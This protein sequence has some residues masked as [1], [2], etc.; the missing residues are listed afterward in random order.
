MKYVVWATVA[1]YSLGSFAADPKYNRPDV[2]QLQ[3][4]QSPVPWQQAAPLDSLPK[5][6]W[7]KIFGDIELDQY[8]DRAIANNQT[9]RAA[10][11]RLAEARAFARVT[12]AGLYPELDTGVSA[13]RQRLSANRPTNGATI[14]SAAVT[15]NVF[16]IP[17]T[18][19]YEVDLFGRVRRSLDAANASLQ[20]S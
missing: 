7:W 17:F 20:A 19:S 1:L 16:S 15:Q 4:W 14:T 8:E 2:P 3:G 10:T 11:A 5:N 9:L 12:S 18:L 13:Q 6:T